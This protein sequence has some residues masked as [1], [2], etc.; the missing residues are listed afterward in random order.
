VRIPTDTTFGIGLGAP[1]IFHLDRLEIETGAE[2]EFTDR[3]RD[4]GV[5]ANLDLPITVLFTITDILF[6]GVRT[7]L[8]LPGFDAVDFPLG[9]VAGAGIRVSQGF[10]LNPI[11]QFTFDRFITSS[12]NGG[13]DLE[14]WTL[15][16]GVSA[17]IQ[18]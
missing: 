6:A 15:I 2:L 13:F 4:S 18:L 16:V 12:G 7:G 8:F 11:A 3:A 10:L 1:M 5:N 9:A 14:V 17:H